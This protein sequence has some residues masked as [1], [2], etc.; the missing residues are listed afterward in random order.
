M[1][2]AIAREA[3]EV[4]RRGKQPYGV[5]YWDFASDALAKMNGVSAN[6]ETANNNEMRFPKD[7]NGI[8]YCDPSGGYD[9]GS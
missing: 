6:A 2:L 7:A 1:T 9:G 5:N 8:E 3:L 4:L